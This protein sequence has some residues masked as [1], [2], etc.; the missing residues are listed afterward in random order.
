[1]TRPGAVKILDMGLARY[2]P[3]GDATTDPLTPRG[4]SW[5]RRT[6]WPRSRPI[7]SHKADIR[8]DLYS[9]G[10]TFYYLLTGRPPFPG[11]R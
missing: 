3:D 7:D 1:M 10:C 6:T 8:A 2:G 9:L 5:A 11:G 4:R